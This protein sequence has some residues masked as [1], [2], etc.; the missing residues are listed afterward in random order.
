MWLGAVAAAGL[1]L[2]VSVIAAGAIYFDRYQAAARNPP[3]ATSTDTEPAILKNHNVVAR[4]AADTARG[5][6]THSN[7][8]LGLT[9]TEAARKFPTCRVSS[10]EGGIHGDWFPPLTS[11]LPPIMDLLPNLNGQTLGSAQGALSARIPVPGGMVPT[12][13]D[14]ILEYYHFWCGDPNDVNAPSYELV[15]YQSRIMV[16]SKTD[17]DETYRSA[18]TVI[19]DLGPNLPGNHSEIHEATA[20]TDGAHEL[21][22]YSDDGNERIVLEVEDPHLSPIN[23]ERTFT[24]IQMGYVDLPLWNS[25]S[26]RVVQ[27]LHRMLDQDKQREREIR[28]SL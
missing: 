24:A 2:L 5:F 3:S 4:D 12:L 11:Y 26:E 6:I 10:S 19:D 27:K 21:V 13:D 16:I 17:Y 7:A 23:G 15:T 8:P 22:E 18:Q 28:N 14:S 20:Y 25:Y 1:V 9:L